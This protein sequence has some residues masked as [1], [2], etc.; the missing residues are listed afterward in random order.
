MEMIPTCA[1]M[2]VLIAQ[3]TVKTVTRWTP[4]VLVVDEAS[5]EK[6]LNRVMIGTSV[7]TSE[8]NSWAPVTNT[9][10]QVSTVEF[11]V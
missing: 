10:R 9:L 7:E 3:K 6:D 2:G 11:G 8:Q 1:L 5:A 4:K